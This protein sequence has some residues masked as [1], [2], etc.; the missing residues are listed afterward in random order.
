M[1]ILEK[2]SRYIQMARDAATMP[3]G[4]LVTYNAYKYDVLAQIYDKTTTCGLNVLSRSDRN[5]KLVVCFK[6]SVYAQDW[7]R[8]FWAWKLD[9]PYA[10]TTP[11]M[12]KVKIHAGF[13]DEYSSVRVPML[14]ELSDIIARRGKPQH[15]T[16]CGHSLVGA[17]ASIAALDIHE[18]F[19]AQNAITS[20][21]SFASP[22]AY[23]DDGAASFMA[24]MEYA[25]RASYANDIVPQVPTINYKH[26]GKPV[27]VK[28]DMSVE[29]A[30]FNKFALLCTPLDHF[31]E[32]YVNAFKYLNNMPGM[33][34]LFSQNM[35][36]D[37]ADNLKRPVMSAIRG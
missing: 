2:F 33:A 5:D 34:D 24:K 22:R 23:N 32:N 30:D 7:F 10:K 4:T 6:G 35:S 19:D 17:L 28:Q 26:V 21:Y 37:P 20:L 18:S 15:V 8:D 16:V 31:V 1:D 14:G 11:D 13:K 12:S 25:L 36:D 27:H 9:W 3:V 29:F